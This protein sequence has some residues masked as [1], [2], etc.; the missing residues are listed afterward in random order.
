MIFTQFS[1]LFS[2]ICKL[3]CILGCIPVHF[4]P[5]RKYVF[6]KTKN[7][8][9]YVA[10]VNI[11]FYASTSF[12]V[13][14]IAQCYFFKEMSSFDSII[15]WGS[16]GV[17]LAGL[18]FT[19]VIRDKATTGVFCVNAIFK[20]V[21]V[22]PKKSTNEPLPLSTK[23]SLAFIVCAMA[24][25]L[26]FPMGVLYVI[27]WYNPCKPS[28]VGYWLLMECYCPRMRINHDVLNFA[29]KTIVFVA[30]HCVWT[31]A[32]GATTFC[33]SVLIIIGVT[34]VRQFLERFVIF[35]Y[36]Y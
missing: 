18:P 7:E 36:V 27:H 11:I 30:N 12:V 31:Y 28:L 16:I 3:T 29:T 33:L 5:Y 22:L 35:S 4:D 20:F 15:A 9:A 23:L 1:A 13:V 21:V 8:Q 32:L 19:K 10:K 17:M 24:S 34:A 6:L 14:F 2:S 25:V 26:L